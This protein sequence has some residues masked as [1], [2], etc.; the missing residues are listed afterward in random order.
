MVSDPSPLRLKFQ[1][2]LS[3][4]R[5]T[6]VIRAITVVQRFQSTLSMRRAT[7]VNVRSL[8]SNLEF[9]STLS[10]RRATYAA[11]LAVWTCQISIHALHEESDQTRQ[12][13]CHGRC[14]SI[15][16]LHEESDCSEGFRSDNSAIS[17]HALHEESDSTDYDALTQAQQFQSTLSMRRATWATSP[18]TPRTRTFQSTLSMR[19]ATGCDRHGLPFQHISI[20]ALHE[21]SDRGVARTAIT[22]A[23]FN[24][25]SP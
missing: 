1:S 4:R 11:M 10:M 6:G 23:Y 14:I 5:A 25:R 18:V 22:S 16:A 21:E 7:R 17:I 8:C 12:N 24:P 3:M 13:Q 9:Q 19:R 2:T 20:H 15:H